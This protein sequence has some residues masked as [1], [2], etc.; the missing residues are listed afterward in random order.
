MWWL[1]DLV[2]VLVVVLRVDLVEDLASLGFCSTFL[3]GLNRG[4]HQLVLS[5]RGNSAGKLVF[6]LSYV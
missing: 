4:L 5:L 2:V 3:A 6:D 1:C